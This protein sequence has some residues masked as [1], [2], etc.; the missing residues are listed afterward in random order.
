[1]LYN[2]VLVSATHQH[3]SATGIHLSSPPSGGPTPAAPSAEGDSKQRS[4]GE[5]TGDWQ[6]GQGEGGH[7]DA[8]SGRTSLVTISTSN[9]NAVMR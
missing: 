2:V 8:Q 1:M 5:G 7:D 6:E 3:E 4:V 9:L